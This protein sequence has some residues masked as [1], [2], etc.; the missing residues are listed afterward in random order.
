MRALSLFIIPKE[1]F[2]TTDGYH[3]GSVLEI[4]SSGLN[5]RIRR[6]RYLFHIERDLAHR[7]EDSRRENDLNIAKRLIKFMFFQNE[8]NLNALGKNSESIRNLTMGRMRGK[9]LI[10][11][12]TSSTATTV[13]T[14]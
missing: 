3:Y 10:W 12:Y 1:I 9:S 8:K 2:I 5:V 4:V 14:Q 13:K 11:Y 6:Q 7:I